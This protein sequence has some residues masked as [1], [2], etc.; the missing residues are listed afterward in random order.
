MNPIPARDH[1]PSGI[2]TYTDAADWRAQNSYGNVPNDPSSISRYWVDTAAIQE[3]SRQAGLNS[4]NQLFPDLYPMYPKSRSYIIIETKSDGITPNR[5]TSLD[6]PEFY[7]QYGRTLAHYQAVATMRQF[8]FVY[9]ALGMPPWLRMISI[10]AEQAA[11][12]TLS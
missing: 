5:H 6:T 12:P 8:K 11:T 7:E 9:D 3:L 10:P 4:L 1:A 2:K